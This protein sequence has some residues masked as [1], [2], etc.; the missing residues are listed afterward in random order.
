MRKVEARIKTPFGEIVIEGENAQEVLG[1]LESFPQDFVEKVSDFVSNRLVPSGVQLKGVVEFT[2]EGP[3][4]IARE[5]LTHYKAI[6]L[7][8]YASEE[9]KNTAAQIQKLLE[10]SGIKCMVPARLNEMTKRGQVFKPDPSKPEFKLT[11]Q[12]ERWVEDEVLARLR[13]KMT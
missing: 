8:L 7:T 6:G 4:I 10:S 13:G 5:N 1:L 9:K 2:T 3:V 12:G 11:V